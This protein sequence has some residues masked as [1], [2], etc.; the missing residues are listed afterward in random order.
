MIQEF[1][2]RVVFDYPH[3]YSSFG[4]DRRIIHP[5]FLRFIRLRGRLI[6]TRIIKGFTKY[7]F[8]S[9]KGPSGV[10]FSHETKTRLRRLQ[11]RQGEVKHL[12]RRLKI[13]KPIFAGDEPWV[14]ITQ[15]LL[16]YM[17]AWRKQKRHPD[18]APIESFNKSISSLST[19]YPYV[20]LTIHFP[21][22]IMQV[23]SEAI[24]EG[25]ILK[26]KKLF[27]KGLSSIYDTFGSVVFDPEAFNLSFTCDNKITVQSR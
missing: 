21:K 20:F 8:S 5:N 15:I 23:L 11:Q 25:D 13:Q 10:W 18:Y 24:K 2:R 6:F 4:K 3:R 9:L 26:Q 16:N 14:P 1:E 27:K 17:Y 22:T 7:F 19:K 12:A